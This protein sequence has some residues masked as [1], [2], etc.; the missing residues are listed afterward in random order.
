MYIS[1][2]EYCLR[3]LRRKRAIHSCEPCANPKRDKSHK[4]F[5]I[6]S[7]LAFISFRAIDAPKKRKARP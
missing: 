3:L 1:L 5:D 4:L 6:F 7:L 2:D